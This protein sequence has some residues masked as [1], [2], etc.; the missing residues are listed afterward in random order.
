M[1]KEASPEKVVQEIRR[2][3]R[4]RCSAEEKIRIVPEGTRAP[5]DLLATISVMTPRRRPR[6]PMTAEVCSLRRRRNARIPPSPSLVAAERV[7][8]TGG[9]GVL[10]IPDHAALHEEVLVRPVAAV[11]RPEEQSLAVHD[12][13]GQRELLQ[14]LRITCE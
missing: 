5:P 1:R 6:T 13:K 9:D 7:D 14:R 2:K 10:V 4:R 3:T 11:F 12:L 8:K